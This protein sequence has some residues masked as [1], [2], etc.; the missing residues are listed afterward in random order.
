MGKRRQEFVLQS[1]RPLRLVPRRAQ[2]QENVAKVVL[3]L[4]RTEGGAH[5]ADHGG[6]AHRAIEKGDV[7]ELL[8]QT[9]RPQR[10]ANTLAAGKQQHRDVRPRGLLLER[11]LELQQLRVV[12]R[13]LGQQDGAGAAVNFGAQFGNTAADVTG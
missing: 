4:P 5:R 1:I 6:E 7:A 9:Q 10:R 11:R 3:P 2:F 12:E 8:Q 13:F